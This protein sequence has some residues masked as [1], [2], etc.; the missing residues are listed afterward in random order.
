MEKLDEIPGV[1]TIVARVIIAEVGMDMSRFPTA[2]TAGKTDT[3]LGERYRRIAKL[4]VQDDHYD[5]R[6]AI[7]CLRHLACSMNSWERNP[8]GSLCPCTSVTVGGWA[9][10]WMSFHGFPRVT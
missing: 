7:W 9:Y 1:G 8:S 3:F 6:P 2:V 4:F 5:G 10:G